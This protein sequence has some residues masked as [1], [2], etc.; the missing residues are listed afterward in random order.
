MDLLI[1]L[2][3]SLGV[4]WGASIALDHLFDEKQCPHC[5]EWKNARHMIQYVPDNLGAETQYWHA[6]CFLLN[7]PEQSTLPDSK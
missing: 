1:L 2:F 4:F 3:I 7:H 5:R 6:S